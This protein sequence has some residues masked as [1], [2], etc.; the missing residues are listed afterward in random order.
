MKIILF[1]Q[2]SQLKS[3]DL[4]TSKFTPYS[5]SDWSQR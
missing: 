3:Q 2:F 5:D 4:E 1:M